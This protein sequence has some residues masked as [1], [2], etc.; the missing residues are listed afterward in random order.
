MTNL[1]GHLRGLSFT[2]ER[3][4]VLA[5]LRMILARDERTEKSSTRN[6]LRTVHRASLGLERSKVVSVCDESLDARVLQRYRKRAVELLQ[7]LAPVDVAFLDLVEIRL[8]VR[9]ELHVEDVGERLDHHALDLV[10]KL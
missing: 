6:E 2:A 4:S 10:A 7:H 1:V 5:G 9:R 8:H 3:T